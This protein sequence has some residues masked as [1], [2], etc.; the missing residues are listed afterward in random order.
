MDRP[1]RE[2]MIRKKAIEFVK[3][4]KNLYSSFEYECLI[5]GLNNIDMPEIFTVEIVREILD[6][7]GYIP[8]NYNIYDS[9]SSLI[10]DIHGVEGKNIIEI[11]G[12]RFP[13]LGKRISL[14]QA[15]GSVT[16]Y[17]PNLF[18]DYSLDNLILKRKMASKNTN[19]DDCDLLIGL[20]PCKGAEVVLDL[21]LDN[22][23]DFMLWLCEGGPHGDEFD[24]FEDDREWRNSLIGYTCNKAKNNGMGDIKIKYLD[25]FSSN[26]PII[27][28]VRNSK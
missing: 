1:T 4:H 24:F 23:K 22:N 3:K 21:A 15:K 14:M 2:L 27:Y 26:F 11:G 16:V 5:D 28:N 17:D 20:M 9:Y 6:E 13:C 12:G 25:R 8:N 19:V 18:A 10:D 7:L